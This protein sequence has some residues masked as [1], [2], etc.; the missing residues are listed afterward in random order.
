MIRSVNQSSSRGMK[1][2]ILYLITIIVMTAGFSKNVT[3]QQREPAQPV[4]CI[5]PTLRAQAAEIKQ[6]F[7]SQGFTVY[8]D[9]MINMSSME[10]F[11]IMVQFAAGHLYQIIFVGQPAATNHKMVMYDGAENKL[12]EKFVSRRNGTD[13]TNYIIYEFSPERTDMYMLTFMTRLKN[14]DFCGSVCIVSAD[15]SKGPIRYTPYMP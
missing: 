9:A 8:R 12:D 3:A 10:P 7:V 4:G 1:K 14:K 15:G 6:H 11:P 13:V 5:D 2:S